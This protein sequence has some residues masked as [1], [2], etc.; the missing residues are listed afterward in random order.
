MNEKQPANPLEIQPIVLDQKSPLPSAL[1]DAVESVTRDPNP[2]LE[3][4]DFSDHTNNN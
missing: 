2:D 1:Q 3:H 4:F